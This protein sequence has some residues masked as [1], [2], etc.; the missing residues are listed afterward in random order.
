MARS[1]QESDSGS[2]I[3]GIY[4]SKNGNTSSGGLNCPKGQRLYDSNM[5]PAVYFTPPDTGETENFVQLTQDAAP[6]VMPYYAISNYGRVINMYS[7]QIMKPNYRPNGYEYLCLAAEGTNAN[8]KPSQRKYSTHR[9]VMKTFDP[10]EDMDNLQV[11]HYNGNKADNYIHKTMPD[12][13]VQ[14][15]LEWST[16]SEN[17]LHRGMLAPSIRCKLSQYD[18]YEIRRLHDEEGYS[19]KRIMEEKFPQVSVSAIQNVCRNKT[20]VD[21]EYVPKENVYSINQ[22]KYKQSSVDRYNEI[23]ELDSERIKDLWFHGYTPNDIKQIFFPCYTFDAINNLICKA[24]EERYNQEE[25]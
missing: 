16:P 13:S 20:Y 22:P 3:N 6:G 5:K 14:S 19:Y 2:Y 17:A 11:N 7:G 15:N 23:G 21:P 9:M 8:G 24:M 1:T 25:N 18:A 4:T 12:G 10:V